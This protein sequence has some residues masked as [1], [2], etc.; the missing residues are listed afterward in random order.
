LADSASGHGRVKRVQ[1]QTFRRRACSAGTDVDDRQL[2][3]IRQGLNEA[4]HV[5]DGGAMDLL[6]ESATSNSCGK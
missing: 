1:E 5:V 3:A 4:G 6:G 2:G